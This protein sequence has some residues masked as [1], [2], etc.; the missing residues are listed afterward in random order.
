M[1]FQT[2]LT[3]FSNTEPGY[4]N[5]HIP[6]LS[7]EENIVIREKTCSQEEK[8]TFVEIF[9]KRLEA[10]ANTLKEDSSLRSHVFSFSQHIEDDLNINLSEVFRQCIVASIIA[11]NEEIISIPLN[12]YEE[13]IKFSPVLQQVFT[14]GSFEKVNTIRVPCSPQEIKDYFYCSKIRKELAPYLA[15]KELLKTL[16]FETILSACVALDFFSDDDLCH[17]LENALYDKLEEVSQKELLSNYSNLLHFISFYEEDDLERQLA[18]QTNRLFVKNKEITEVLSNFTELAQQLNEDNL[19]LHYLKLS[20]VELEGEQD[21]WKESFNEEKE[22]GAFDNVEQGALNEWAAMNPSDFFIGAR[23]LLDST[24]WAPIFERILGSFFQRLDAQADRGNYFLE[25]L[26]HLFPSIQYL[27]IT[28]TSFTTCAIPPIWRNTLISFNAA[29]SRG[30]REVIGLENLENIKHIFLG[31][32]KVGEGPINC[33]NLENFQAGS[34]FIDVSKLDNLPKLRHVS[35]GG[36]LIERAPIGCPQLRYFNAP[37]TEHFK[38]SSGV[39]HLTKDLR[40]PVWG[41]L[42]P[43]SDVF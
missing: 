38:D 8:N 41:E 16:T 11:N 37:L 40:N 5:T 43:D 33:P 26:S 14:N 7:S 2:F 3:D 23:D 28:D 10:L 17:L 30:L 36:S 19:T 42:D 13:T 15:R 25:Q 4:W 12:I 31:N 1:N 27:N 9:S 34:N 21:A 24:R 29:F 32:T 6:E 39:D 22:R 20:G 35:A 18:N